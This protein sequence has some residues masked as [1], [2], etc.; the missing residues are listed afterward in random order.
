MQFEVEGQRS[1]VKE[2]REVVQDLR[3]L[4]L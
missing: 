2:E 3:A 4:L 1:E